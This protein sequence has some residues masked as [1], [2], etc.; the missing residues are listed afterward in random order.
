MFWISI[1]PPF[2]VKDNYKKYILHLYKAT[3][4]NQEKNDKFFL[5]LIFAK[6][7]CNHRERDTKYNMF[8]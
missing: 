2:Y 5:V 7:A 1:L 6:V 8:N 4:T 3:N